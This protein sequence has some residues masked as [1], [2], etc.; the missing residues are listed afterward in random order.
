MNLKI[1]AAAADLISI[2]HLSKIIHRSRTWIY[3]RI[4]TDEI[5][6]PVRYCGKLHWKLQ[7][8]YK[9]LQDNQHE[10]QDIYKWM[11]NNPLYK[12]C[13]LEK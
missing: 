2:G 8:V 9:W 3:R 7:D 5:P 1:F 11:E 4:G 12:D 13:K 10:L 6:K